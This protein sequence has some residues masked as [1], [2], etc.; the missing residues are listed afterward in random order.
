MTEQNNSAVRLC[1]VDDLGVGEALSVCVAK[2]LSLAVI[3]VN[4]EFFAI[5]NECT[6]GAGVLTDGFVDED[7]IVCPV[8]AGEFHIP[9][10]K[11]L[12]LPVSED[13]RTYAVWVEGADVMADLNRP[14]Q[15]SS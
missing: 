12:D 8:H 9:S 4:G 2:T 6:H 5:A 11:A 1:G 3:N 10:G 13:L 7:V 15:A 14:A